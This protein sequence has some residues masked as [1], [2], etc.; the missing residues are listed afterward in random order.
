MGK[1]LL[2]I[3]YFDICLKQVVSKGTQT[4]NVDRVRQC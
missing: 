4:T 2:D 3:A 1:R